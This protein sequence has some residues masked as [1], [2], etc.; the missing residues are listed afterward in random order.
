MDEFENNKEGRTT[1][2]RVKP[3]PF[4]KAK[5]VRFDG[6]H[7]AGSIQKQNAALQMHVVS[8]N[9]EQKEKQRATLDV[10]S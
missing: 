7:L 3:L 8:T 6:F 4:S 9:T 1:E 2:L 5:S 10:G